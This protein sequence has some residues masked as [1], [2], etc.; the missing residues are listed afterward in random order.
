MLV[1]QNQDQRA[2]NY[3]FGA[4]TGLNQAFP[5]VL[6]LDT[7]LLGIV[8]LMKFIFLFFPVDFVEI[9][10]AQASHTWLG[11]MNRKC[12]KKK[13]YVYTYISKHEQTLLWCNL[14]FSAFRTSREKL[15]YL[16]TTSISRKEAIQSTTLLH[17]KLI[18]LLPW[19]SRSS[20]IICK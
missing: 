3:Q 1:V 7:T 16:Q 15:A 10:L 18:V 11:N 9:R 8:T 14:I 13:L 2:I 5:F 12:E 17:D 4:A 6:V 19:V 20:W